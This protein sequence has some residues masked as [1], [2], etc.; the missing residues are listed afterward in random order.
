VYVSKEPQR[1]A[2]CLAD[3][4]GHEPHTQVD[5]VSGRKEGQTI[6]EEVYSF[7]LVGE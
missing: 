7:H 1:A 4:F 3:L 6:P 5:L 2:D